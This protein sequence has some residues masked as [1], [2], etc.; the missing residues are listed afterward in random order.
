MYMDSDSNLQA[1]THRLSGIV[2][3]TLVGHWLRKP[4]GNDAEIR[5][6]RRKISQERDAPQE[7]RNVA[8]GK[9]G[10]RRA[11]EKPEA[12]DRHWTVRSTQKGRKSS[13]K[14][15]LEQKGLSA[16]TS[17][18]CISLPATFCAMDQKPRAILV[19]M[20]ANLII[21]VSRFTA[22][23]FSGS[24]AMLSEGLH[25]VVDAGDGPPLLYGLYRGQR[26]ADDA[27]PS[28]HGKELYF[29]TFVA[30]LI[31][32]GGGIVSLS[33]RNS[34]VVASAL[35][36][37]YG[38]LAISALAEG[39]SFRVAYHE[40]RSKAGTDED[41]LPTI[42]GSKDPSTFAILFEGGTVLA[43]LLI[44]FLGLLLAQILYKPYLDAIASIGIALILMASGQRSAR[45]ARR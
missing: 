41:L 9:S 18:F 19:A 6:S 7:A 38:I 5:E 24:A 8:F 32:A 34:P 30:M 13:R 1:L 43:G 14:E 35:A 3:L 25:S 10:Q 16:A 22:S 42:H 15:I 45:A 2:A 11:G 31:F 23:F 4:G 20:G 37:S 27:H 17:G 39:Y 28:G 29:W 40:F 33:P 21:A 36:W 44:A 12:S 26:P